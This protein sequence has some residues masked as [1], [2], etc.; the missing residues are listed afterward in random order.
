[1]DRLTFQE[2]IR[3]A[4]PDAYIYADG[5][6]IL[7]KDLR[8]VF[9]SDGASDIFGF[10]PINALDSNI[11]ILQIKELSDTFLQQE[12]NFFVDKFLLGISVMPRGR[13]VHG[14][15]TLTGTNT[16]TK[17]SVHVLCGVHPLVISEIMHLVI[18]FQSIATRDKK[19]HVAALTEPAS[20]FATK[21]GSVAEQAIAVGN[22]IVQLKPR[23]FLAF[24]LSASFIAVALFFWKADSIEK[25]IEGRKEPAAGKSPAKGPSAY[26]TDDERVIHFG[27][28]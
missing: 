14:G 6:I 5:A 3:A 23:Q 27:D 1:L 19:D 15:A 25:I 9:L 12:L 18:F 16:I 21:T 17:A 4:F 28:R 10:H 24:L 2:H 11:S 22:W 20:P 7:D 8:I 13:P 26:E